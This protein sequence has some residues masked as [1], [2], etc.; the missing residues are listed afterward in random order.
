MPKRTAVQ[1]RAREIQQAEGIGYHDAL[2]RAQAEAA[3]EPATDAL[4]SAPAAVAYVLQP[5]AAEAE[6]GITAEEL[7][8]RALPA[9]ATPGQRAHAEAVWRPESDPAKPCRC[10]GECR[11]GEACP[12]DDEGCDGRLIHADRYP[13]SLWG[14]TTWWDTYQCAECGEGFEG[15]VTLPEIPW[16]EQRPNDGAG[17]TTLIYDGVRHPNFGM[18]EA[19]EDELDPDA[20][21]TPE[22]DYYDDEYAADEEALQE[23]DQEEEPAYLDHGPEDD[24]DPSGEPP[25]DY[26]G[27]HP[28]AELGAAAA[29]GAR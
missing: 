6:L 12:F 23:Q 7:G 27:D 24:V 8:V 22:E 14:I 3:T 15:A 19:D 17:F 4:A 18:F 11:H 29:E 28:E 1:K 21:P 2:N 5:T 25:E 16:G 10:S 20:Y 9:D 13:G 26:Y